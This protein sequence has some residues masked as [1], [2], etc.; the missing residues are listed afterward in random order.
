MGVSVGVLTIDLRANTASFSDAMGKM[1]QLSARTANDIKRSLE[2]IGTMGAA[3][4]GSLVVGTSALIETSVATIGG[5][6]RMA[7]QAGTTTEKFSVLAYAAKL[8]HVELGNLTGTMDKLAKASFQAQNGNHALAGVFN[9]LGVSISDTK[10]HLRDTSDMFADVAVKFSKMETGAGKAALAMA[11]FGRS[12]AQMIPLLNDYGAHQAEITEEAKK[13]GLVIGNDVPAKVRAYHE[14][15]TKLHAAQQGFGL[16]LTVAVLPAL[17]ALSERLQQLGSRF[18]VAKL[19]EAAGAKVTKAINAMVTTIDLAT[20]HVKLLEAAL[21]ALAG[22]Q[23]SKI[24]IPVI[25]DLAAGGMA[26]IGTGITKMLLG[27]A[28]LGKVIPQLAVF[29]N[30]VMYTARFVALLASEEGIATA[31]TYVMGG[32]FVA[33]GGWVTVAVLALIGL[34]VAIYKFRD[35]TVTLGGKTYELRDTW[36]AAWILMTKAVDTSVKL[37][38]I[39]LGD[40]KTAWS[41]VVKWI[42]D[43]PIVQALDLKGANERL[44][45][46]AGKFVE[47]AIERLKYANDKL[48]D[49]MLPKTPQ[50]VIGALNQAKSERETKSEVGRLFAKTRTDLIPTTVIPP[51][52]EQ[53]DTSGLGKDKE[54]PVGK[55][56]ANLQEKLDES[57]QTLAAAGLEEQA[58]RKVAAANKA[59]NEILKLGE[60]IAKQTGSKTKDYASLVDDATQALIREK[61]AQISDNE[62]KTVLG[63]LIGTSTRASALNVVQSNL[64]AA[65]M[66]KG[67]DAVI[68]Q[69]A[70][71]QAWNELREKGGTLTQMLTRTQQIYDDSI[72][73]ESL[74]IRGNIISLGLEMAALKINNDAMLS[75]VDARDAAALRSK[76]YALDVQIAGAATGELRD[77]LLALRAA[78]VGMNAE[79]KRT[80][81]LD[82]ARSLQSPAKQYQDQTKQLNDAVDALRKLNRG[83]IT[84][85]ESLSIVVRAQDNIN[86]LI[87]KM[88]SKLLRVGNVMDGVTAFFLDMQR[89]AISTAAIIF[90][91]MKSAFDKLSENLAQLVTAG[92][93]SFAE[94]FKD[95]GKQMVKA[96]IEKGLQKGLGALGAKLGINVGKTSQRFDGSSAENALWVRMAGG[97]DGKVGSYVNELGDVVGGKKDSDSGSSPRKELGDLLGGGN[98]TGGIGTVLSALGGLF[99]KKSGNAG[100]SNNGG[101]TNELGDVIGGGSG[102]SKGGF[103]NELGDLLGG[104]GKSKSGGLTNE[105][106]DALGGSSD[107]TDQGSGKKGGGFFGFLGALFKKKKGMSGDGSDDGGDGDGSS[108]GGSVAGTILGAL[109]G[110]LTAHA[111]GGPVSPGTAYLVGERGPEILSGASGHITSNVAARR[112]LGGAGGS[113]LYYSIDARGT[114]PAQTEQRTRTALLAV[115]NSAIS[116]AV[117]VSAERVKRL[118]MK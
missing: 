115:H 3:M 53:A 70:L 57:K 52:K 86:E 68:R 104:N 66:D 20:K 16:Q 29:G 84:Y 61:N 111:E 39:M 43:N 51:K 94:M 46:Y 17:T 89:E 27:F 26:N 34:G 67:S 21:V 24:A 69:S 109:M 113:T 49:K 13:F 93:T 35:S 97:P 83:A 40:I 102:K 58:Q 38:K 25:A 44:E 76:L 118:P 112:M 32:V 36:N 31:A 75:S 92:K 4:V 11:V 14:V 63:N 22:I 59:S 12:G 106:G 7:K 15:I 99:G 30:W 110:A 23:L 80:A 87:D 55:V 101:Y 41:G 54:S 45:G 28:G 96:N 50:F 37:F 103:S 48:K 108:G 5:L 56:L 6:S 73:R 42:A 114:D 64:A 65:A 77:K 90:S 47:K 95:I 71:T 82:N 105:L 79:Q 100:A 62:A 19:A 81:D 72:A 78:M 8:N 85:G 107:G 1:S 117:Q 91:A 9:R 88:I 74:A 98:K 10:G 116:N 18:D 33:L 60:E 2:K